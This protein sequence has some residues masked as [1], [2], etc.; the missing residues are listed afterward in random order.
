[1]DLEPEDTREEVV[2]SIEDDSHSS[3][4]KK[5][6]R[7]S[8]KCQYSRFMNRIKMN[9]YNI[10]KVLLCQFLF[11]DNSLTVYEFYTVKIKLEKRVL[12]D[13]IRWEITWCGL[14][15]KKNQ[16]GTVPF[17]TFQWT[18]Q[19]YWIF[20]IFWNN[21]GNGGTIKLGTTRAG[22][23]PI[24]HFPKTAMIRRHGVMN[25][26]ATRYTSVKDLPMD[27]QQFQ[28]VIN[29]LNSDYGSKQM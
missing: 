2:L 23:Q 3:I 8:S 21:P 15:E 14:L 7:I 22:Q 29:I 10:L 24:V 13:L 11:K 5:T 25:V 19:I 27:N 18:Y 26:T 17:K 9:K 4:E 20:F 1:M 6:C 28:G 16:K 12:N